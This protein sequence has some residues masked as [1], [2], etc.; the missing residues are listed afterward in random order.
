MEMTRG[1]EPLKRITQLDGLRG[2]AIAAVFFHHAYHIPLLW[3]GVDLFFVLSGFLITSILLNNRVMPF[4]RYLGKFYEKR[5][6]RIL[7]PYVIVLFLTAAL[8]GV[9][10]LRYWYLYFGAMNFLFPLGL[11][12]Q[13]TLPLWSLAVEEQFYLIWPL[14][15]FYLSV[16]NLTRLAF[17]LVVLAP[18]LRLVFTPYFPNQWAIYMLLPFRMDTLAAGACIALC[19]PKLHQI[20]EVNYQF[21][22]RLY[23]VM[24]LALLGGLSFLLWASKNG[25]STHANTRVGNVGVYEANLAIV[26]SIFI[27]VLCGF[28]KTSLE[29]WPLTWLG[30]IS[31][32][33]YLIHLTML[34]V[35]PGHHGIFAAAGSL[36]FALCMWFVVERPVL[37]GQ[38]SFSI[39]H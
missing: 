8:F 34:Y 1:S 9:S 24:S 13:E 15:V 20:M 22:V 27:V 4:S 10:W 25:I 6:R 17:F 2:I 32:S 30:R 38:T 14:A 31:Y 5:A 35:L 7:P 36:V 28:A 19:W 3:A 23:L 29:S 11:A 21:R 37:S 39:T 26:V 12:S 18:V 33:F 16:R